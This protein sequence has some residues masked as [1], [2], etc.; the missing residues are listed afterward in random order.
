MLLGINIGIRLLL[1]LPPY[2]FGNPILLPLASFSVCNPATYAHMKWSV[3]C[4]ETKMVLT[5]ME[6]G[7][8]ILILNDTRGQRTKYTQTIDMFTASWQ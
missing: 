2:D 3:D 8:S 7:L 5:G 6:S 4:K 1:S